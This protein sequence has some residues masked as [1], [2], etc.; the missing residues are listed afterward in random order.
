MKGMRT[1]KRILGRDGSAVAGTA[2]CL[3][4]LALCGCHEKEKAAPPPPPS[5]VVSEVVPTD[6]PI[7][8]EYVAQTQSSRQVNIQARVS[9]F[10]EKRMY[11]EGAIVNAGDVLFLMDK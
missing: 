6:T 4:A 11:T 5:V 3:A 8:F 1:L 7:V 10:L 2:L 9:G